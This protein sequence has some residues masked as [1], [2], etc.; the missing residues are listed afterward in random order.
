[1]A[2]L[3]MGVLMMGVLIVGMSSRRIEVGSLIASISGRTM[4]VRERRSIEE[5]W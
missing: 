1:M 3:T 2:V 5:V 4:R